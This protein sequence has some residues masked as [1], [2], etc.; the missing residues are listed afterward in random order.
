[1]TR[2]KPKELQAK[3]QSLD[4]LPP[5]AK[6]ALGNANFKCRDVLTHVFS[7]Y[8]L[9]IL[10]QRAMSWAVPHAAKRGN[11]RESLANLFINFKV[12]GRLP[13]VGLASPLFRVRV[14]TCRA[15]GVF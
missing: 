8:S 7:Y 12:S 10:E 14:R 6:F 3:A 1:M 2:Q 11:W 15:P 5:K 9:Q 4:M 13:G